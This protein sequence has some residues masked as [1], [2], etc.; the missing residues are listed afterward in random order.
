M[1]LLTQPGQKSEKRVF[2]FLLSLWFKVIKRARHVWGRFPVRMCREK[3]VIPFDFYKNPCA[4]VS[5][6]VGGYFRKCTFLLGVI[7]S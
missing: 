3:T 2:L 4:L 1:G 7:V 5:E 6:L